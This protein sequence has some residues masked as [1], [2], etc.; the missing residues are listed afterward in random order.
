MYQ[1]QQKG[2]ANHICNR[3]KISH[4]WISLRIMNQAF[5]RNEVKTVRYST[6]WWDQKNELVAG[7]LNLVCQTASTG[8]GCMAALVIYSHMNL[9]ICHIQ[10]GNLATHITNNQVFLG[11][12]DPTLGHACHNPHNPV[13]VTGNYVLIIYSESR[14]IYSCTI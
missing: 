8:G 9:I 12:H 4:L 1:K 6:Y 5:S 2:W 7:K 11:V 14:I 10:S 3:A 13:T